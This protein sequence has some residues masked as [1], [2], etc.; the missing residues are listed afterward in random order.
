MC[1]DGRDI[2]AFLIEI[3]INSGDTCFCKESVIVPLDKGKGP[4]NYFDRLRPVALTNILGKITERVCFL[5]LSDFIQLNLLCST[6]VG[7]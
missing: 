2:L 7:L 6:S 1:K 4:N 5:F 3:S